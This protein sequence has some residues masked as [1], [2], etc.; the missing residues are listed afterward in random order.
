M[1]GEWILVSPQRISRPWQGKME[2]EPPRDAP[3]YDRECYLCPGNRRASGD[4]NPNY[5]KTFVFN[6]DFSALDQAPSAF[7]P[8]AAPLLRCESVKGTCRVICYSPRH[9]LTLPEMD[10]AAIQNVVETWME[11]HARLARVYKWIQFFENKGETMG[12]SNPHP[13]GQVWALDRLTTVAGKEDACQREYFAG[14]GSPLLLDYLGTEAKKGERMVVENDHWA[15]LVPFWAV[16]PYETILVPKRHIPTISE[17]D[18]GERL[19]LARILKALTVRYDNLM[20]TS[21]PYCMGWHSAPAV[22]GAGKYWQ[23][24]AHFFPPLL[25]SVKVRKFMVGF[26]MLSEP[27]RDITPEDAAARLREM[28]DVHYKSKGRRGGSARR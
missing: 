14:R 22:K 10:E 17:L 5:K 21:F 11:E 18:A 13:H 26:E 3:A 12:C 2:K 7:K 28:P 16:W 4:T 1:T 27:Q 24:H 8:T 9:D 15:V 25:R 23:L 6:N 19:T 20:Q